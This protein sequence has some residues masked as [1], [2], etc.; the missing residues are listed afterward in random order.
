[1]GYTMAPLS[2]KR[3]GIALAAQ[4]VFPALP[5]GDE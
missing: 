5:P 4:D 1:T 2:D 3:E